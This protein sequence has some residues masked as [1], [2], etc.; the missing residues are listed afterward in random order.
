VNAAVVIDCSK[1][2][3][4]V[5]AIDPAARIA[6]VEPGAVCD[7]LRDAAEAH[8]LTFAPDPATHSRCT[9]GGMIGNNSCGPHSV[10][11]GKAVENIERLEVLT[12]DGARFWCGPT[13]ADELKKVLEKNDRQTGASATSLNL[14]AKGNDPIVGWEDAAVDPLRLGDYLREFQ[15]L[16][17]RFGY[18]TSLY[19]HF[20]DGCIH[21]RLDF[22][23]RS[24]TGVAHWRGFL[25]AARRPGGEVRRLALRRARRRPGESR[26]PAADVRPGADAGVSRVQ[27][28]VGSRNRMN[29]GK[30]I[31]AYAADSH[32]RLGPDYQPV[33]QKT[34]FAFRSEVGDG[35]VRA[36]EHCVGMGKCRSASGATMCPELPGAPLREKTAPEAGAGDGAHRR[37]GAARREAAA[38]REL[39][40]RARKENHR[41]GR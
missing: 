36:T 34:V 31:N 27:G 5:L 19:G 33:P 13:S 4:R 16:V 11:A 3:G 17:A 29:P 30:L 41:H 8:R 2:M 10:M 9:L 22:D 40:R 28:G 12:Y 15:A 6:R 24:R 1:Y 25:A 23:L 18:R 39:P 14:G 35:F 20:G 37:M 32:L 7:A 38:P 26:V 21:A